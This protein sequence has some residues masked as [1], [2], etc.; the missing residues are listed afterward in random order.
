MKRL[1][2]SGLIVSFLLVCWLGM[3]IV[4]ELGH[5]L[6]AR[7]TGGTIVTV[8]L[9]PTTI[10]RTKVFPNPHPLIEVWAGPLV[11]PILPLLAYL[12][13][14]VLRCPGRYLFRFFVGFCLVANGSYILAGA[15]EQMGDPGELLRYGAHLWQL[16]SFG[17]ITTSAGF[18]LWNKLGP[19]F[20]LGSANGQVNS[21]A[22]VF[23]LAAFASIC[24]I[25]LLLSRG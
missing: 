24:A 21:A 20:G 8:V 19:K 17:L 10:S 16:I 7:A 23:S 14:A 25:E 9:Y 5:I 15:F 11:G 1:E 12:I 4:H 13:A 3:Q 18:F 6:A 22:T 2:Q